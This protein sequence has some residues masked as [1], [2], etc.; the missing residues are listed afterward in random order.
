LGFIERRDNLF[1]ESPQN[2]SIIVFAI[3]V[4][5]SWKHLIPLDF[6]PNL[7]DTEEAGGSNANTRGAAI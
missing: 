1:P 7:S 5:V 3:F 4:I 6:L 2:I